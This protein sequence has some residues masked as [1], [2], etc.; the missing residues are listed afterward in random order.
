[1]SF[2]RFLKD[3]SLLIGLIIGALCTV[4]IF[5]LIYNLEVYI[6][7]YIL[8]AILGALFLGLIIEYFQKKKYYEKLMKQIDSLDEKYFINEVMDK[9]TF[10]E[11]EVMQELM[12]E[13][14][15]DRFENVRKYQSIQEEY[16]EYI[17][18]WIHEIKIPIATAKLISDNN[19]N[20]FTKRIS[21]ELDSVEDYV[22]Q[23]LFYARSNT[24]EK[25]YIIRPTNL[26]QVVSEVIRKNKNALISSKVKV[27]LEDLDIEVPTDSK[28]LS[29]I[30]NQLI[31][32]SIKYMDKD[33]PE[34]KISAYK[35]G[36]NVALIIEDNGIGISSEELGRVFDK[37]FTGANGRM[38][39]KKS[40]GIGLYLAKKLCN[41]MEHNINIESEEGKGTKV[42]LFIPVSS[43]VNL[44]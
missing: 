37:G 43:F 32:N 6:K 19:K 42:S 24:L 1:M 2:V 18:L 34:I 9:P 41:K 17:E 22:D 36:E 16:K 26:K 33:E 14:E 8:F 44:T 5:L 11:G 15:K 20:E 27:S 12:R 3:K 40:T 31:G 25:D 29:F 38:M 39:G 4:E 21:N 23:A 35:N 7:L 13:S 10:F 28:W 30:L